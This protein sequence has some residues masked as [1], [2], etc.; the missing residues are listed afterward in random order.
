MNVSRP[1]A[2]AAT[3]S[4]HPTAFVGCRDATSAPTSAKP[5]PI[6]T[7]ASDALPWRTA[8]STGVA[9]AS[10]TKSPNRLHASDRARRSE[11]TRTLTELSPT[12]SPSPA[13]ME[14]LI[15][16]WTTGSQD[17]VQESLRFRCAVRRA[18]GARGGGV[19]IEVSLLGPPRVERAG[20]LVGFDTRKAVA[21]LAHLALADRP[22]PRDALA[23]L[24]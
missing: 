20:T 15:R 6:A 2:A 23:D 3:S 7:N 17:T 14:L 24:L 19:V 9:A 13:G 4:S 16:Q 10:P 21:L 8:T 12:P 5:I 11:V 22:R 1:R 18:A